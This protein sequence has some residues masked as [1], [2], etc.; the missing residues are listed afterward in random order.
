M[1]PQQAPTDLYEDMR[2]LNMLYEELMWDH[3]DILEFVADYENNR[4]IV[5]NKTLDKG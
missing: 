5:R 2:K 1:E 3:E 4:I